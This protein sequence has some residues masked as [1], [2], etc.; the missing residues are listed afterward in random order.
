MKQHIQMSDASARAQMPMPF[1]ENE[2]STNEHNEPNCESNNVSILIPML[3]LTLIMM[4]IQ[5]K[6]IIFG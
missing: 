6:V 1:L 3:I 2:E 4:Q 5:M